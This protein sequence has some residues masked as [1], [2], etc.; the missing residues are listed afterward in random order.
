MIAQLFAHLKFEPQ[1]RGGPIVDHDGVL[2]EPVKHTDV[3]VHVLSLHPDWD[4]DGVGEGFDVNLVEKIQKEK[5]FKTKQ[6]LKSTTIN[7]LKK[8]HKI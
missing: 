1:R 5:T 4:V 7:H 8:H 2:I 6:K 3:E